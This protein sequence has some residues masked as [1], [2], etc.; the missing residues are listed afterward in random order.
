MEDKQNQV[1]EGALPPRPVLRHSSDY[2]SDACSHGTA[3]GVSDHEANSPSLGSP[4]H[5][6]DKQ[7]DS[8]AEYYVPVDRLSDPGSL[9]ASDVV[10]VLYPREERSTAGDALTLPDCLLDRGIAV[11]ADSAVVW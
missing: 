8:H 4:H 6:T 10:H 1:M 11:N 3:H 5:S 9:V 7:P 2:S